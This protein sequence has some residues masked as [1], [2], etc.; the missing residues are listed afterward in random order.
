MAKFK[1]YDA[2]EL[3]GELEADPR[4]ANRAALKMVA[5][6]FTIEWVTSVCHCCGGAGR[7]MDSGADVA[8]GNCSGTGRER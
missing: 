7:V 1:V 2:G 5:N 4:A 3:V 8:C 6:G